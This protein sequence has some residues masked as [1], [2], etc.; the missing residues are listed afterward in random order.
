[1][2]DFSLFLGGV[3]F[4][5]FEIPEHIQAGGKQAIAVHQYPGGARTVDAMGPADA[6]LKWS[7]YF[8]GPDGQARCQQLNIMYRQG[9]AIVATWSAYSYL[10]VIKDFTWDFQRY[11]HI[12][13]QIS[14]EVV[15][16]LTAP[17][18]AAAPDVEN[19]IQ[20]DSSDAGTDASGLSALTG[21]P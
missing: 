5:D 10:V 19:Q 2:S 1:M 4:S 17:Q 3:A 20:F 14:L 13:Y 7:G 12:G 16:D 21:A 11:Y 6:P 18:I 8:E 9:A 15:Q